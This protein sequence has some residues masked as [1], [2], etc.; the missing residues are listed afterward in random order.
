MRSQNTELPP[1]L[2]IILKVLNIYARYKKTIRNKLADQIK[3]FKKKKTTKRLSTKGFQ[4]QRPSL[5]TTQ[6]FENELSPLIMKK[7]KI[8]PHTKL[9]DC[10]VFLFYESLEKSDWFS[11]WSFFRTFLSW[12]KLQNNSLRRIEKKGKAESPVRNGL[13]FFHSLFICADFI[14]INIFF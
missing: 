10:T 14:K 2:H 13:L 11:F 4:Y 5:Q 1:L 9:K 8:I 3:G 6:N 12:N 7:I